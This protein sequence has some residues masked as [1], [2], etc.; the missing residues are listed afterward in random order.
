MLLDRSLSFLAIAS[1]IIA[2]IVLMVYI[3]RV[4]QRAG[5]RAVL[6]GLLNWRTL[7]I[8]LLLVCISLLSAALVFIQP[9]NR[10][11]HRDGLHH[12]ALRLQRHRLRRRGQRR[13]RGLRA[14][15]DA[16]ALPRAEERDSRIQ[17]GC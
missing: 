11:R 7:I 9:L 10:M 16:P 8:L 4:L 17:A 1:W 14:E 3:W 6:R 12:Q 5:P 2:G 13:G 15:P